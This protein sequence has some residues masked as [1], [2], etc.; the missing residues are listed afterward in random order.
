MKVNNGMFIAHI[1]VLIQNIVMQK[2][3]KTGIRYFLLMCIIVIIW[4]ILA[5]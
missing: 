1:K 2:L 5:Y 3:L 4:I